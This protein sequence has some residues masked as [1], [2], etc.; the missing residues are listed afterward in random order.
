MN[1]MPLKIIGVAALVMSGMTLFGGLEP[2]VANDAAEKIFI[3]AT[4]DGIWKA[5]DAKTTELKATIDSGKLENVHHDAFAIRDL[6][7]ALPSRSAMLAAEKLG[8]VKTSAKFVATLAERLDATGDAKD[9][10]E[11]KENYTKLTG[12]LTMIRANYSSAP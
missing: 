12:V 8:K 11:T 5:I 2:A 3:P 4:V 7:A 6:V 9:I 1:R 10:A